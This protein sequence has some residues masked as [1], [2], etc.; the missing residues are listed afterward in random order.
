MA[1]RRYDPTGHGAALLPEPPVLPSVT[2]RG[3]LVV[4]EKPDTIPNFVQT[5]ARST[6]SPG[7]RRR[8]GTDAVPYTEF[9]T[10]GGEGVKGR[11][12]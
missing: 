8:C 3:L 10:G 4:K 12:G 1:T 6:S 11:P 5:E 2:V 7:C 9:H